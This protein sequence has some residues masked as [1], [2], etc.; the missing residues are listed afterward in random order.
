MMIK[1]HFSLDN[2]KHTVQSEPLSHKPQP[3][4]SLFFFFSMLEKLQKNPHL[5]AKYRLRGSRCVVP[6]ALEG[7]Q[8]ILTRRRTRKHLVHNLGQT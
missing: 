6:G 4:F 1:S 3:Q 2:T 8:I 5:S 7:L